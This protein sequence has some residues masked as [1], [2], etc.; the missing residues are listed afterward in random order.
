MTDVQKQKVLHFFNVLDHNGN[1]ILQEDDFSEIG[2]SLANQMGHAGNSRERLALKIKAHSLFLQILE[3]LE[4]IEAELTPPEWLKFYKDFI[5]TEYNDY[6]S[7]S[8]DY[9]FSLFD[10]NDDG[11]IDEHEY[12]DMFR[13]YGLYMTHAKKA[14]DLLDLNDDGRISRQ[15]MVKAFRDFFFS[16]DPDA[17]GNWI[18]GDWRKEW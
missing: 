1:G 6:I 17:P 8:S 3:D 18:F 10:Q 2:D 15:E 7:E 14:F 9:L 12:M 11:Y 16:S 5:L 4:K 13:A